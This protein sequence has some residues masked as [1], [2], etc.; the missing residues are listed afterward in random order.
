MAA[1]VMRCLS[2]CAARLRQVGVG[3]ALLLLALNSHAQAL[4]DPTRPPDVS[5]LPAVEGKAA[6]PAGPQLQS[7]LLSPQRKVA[8]ISG[9]SVRLGDKY[10][11]ARLVRLT[12]SA[13]TLRRGRQEQVLH[14][15]SGV[16]KT[17][18]PP[19]AGAPQ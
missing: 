3:S 9:Q 16:R 8:V 13:A 6:A 10:G 1:P 5:A 14:L 15:F 2:A 17:Y 19:A 4:H 11:D 18:G 12:D 7:V